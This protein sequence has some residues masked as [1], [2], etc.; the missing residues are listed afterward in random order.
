MHYYQLG[1]NTIKERIVDVKMEKRPITS[2]INGEDDADSGWFDDR[3]E[4]I[5]EVDTRGLMEAFGNETCLVMLDGTIRSLFSFEDPF[6]SNNIHRRCVG[7]KG[8]CM[9]G[10]ESFIFSDLCVGP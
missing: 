1:E 9:I 2:N 8:P 7:N 5:V 4:N 6:A 3:A 10:E